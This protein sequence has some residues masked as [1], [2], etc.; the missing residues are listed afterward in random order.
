MSISTYSIETVPLWSQPNEL[1]VNQ[2][3]VI[4]LNA[5]MVSFICE[6]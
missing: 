6:V 4:R 3:Y 5:T 1:T 2:N